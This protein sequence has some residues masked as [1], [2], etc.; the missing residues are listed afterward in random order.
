LPGHPLCR[1]VLDVVCKQDVGIGGQGG[2]EDV[3]VLG[4]ISARMWRLQW[5]AIA[6]SSAA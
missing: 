6:P 2:C 5:I 4:V 3:A 1:E